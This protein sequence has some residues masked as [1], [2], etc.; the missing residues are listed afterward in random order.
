VNIELEV[1]LAPELAYQ[2]VFRQA[3]ERPFDVRPLDGAEFVLLPG[4][5]DAWRQRRALARRFGGRGLPRVFAK[6]AT[7]S[8]L[9][10]AVVQ[11]GAL[12]HDGWLSVSRCR[13]YPVA[14]GDV[15]IGPM[16]TTP[17]LRGRG[18]AAYGIQG[19]MNAMLRRGHRVFYIN[20]S[21]ANLASR[22]VID[23]CGF[24][25]PIAVIPR[26]RPGTDRAADRS[27]SHRPVPQIRVRRAR[28][29][30]RPVCGAIVAVSPARRPSPE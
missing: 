4:P 17:P 20:T 28:V 24:G 30:I 10:Y 23:K 5:T 16:A 25:Q 9:L 22:R 7:R 6:L 13:T 29:R 8:R 19:A 18:L 12:V 2:L 26:T 11:N 14:D 3:L 21:P 15:V 1:T 27:A